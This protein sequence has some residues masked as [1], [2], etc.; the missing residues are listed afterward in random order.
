LPGQADARNGSL[1]EGLDLAGLK[2]ALQVRF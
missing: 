1:R 2:Y